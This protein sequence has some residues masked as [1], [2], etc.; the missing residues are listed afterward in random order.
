V[1]TARAW[2]VPLAQAPFS[3]VLDKGS[4]PITILRSAGQRLTTHHHSPQC[5][6]KAHH[7]SPFSAVLGKG[8]PPITILRSAGQRLTTHH[9]A[10]ALRYV[11]T[12][13]TL[14]L[15]HTARR[16]EFQLR[17]RLSVPPWLRHRGASN[18]P[19]WAGCTG[20]HARPHRTVRLATR[21]CRTL[22][23]TS[24]RAGGRAGLT[25]RGHP[26][27]GHRLGQVRAPFGL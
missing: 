8:S 25:R 3:A 21:R 9:H 1:Y 19:A 10:V 18:R 23:S 13:T 17:R 22:T 2:A 12:V 24:R 11:A 15:A 14:A 27:H 5:W 6:A 7:P 4:P 16:V 26:L 20:A